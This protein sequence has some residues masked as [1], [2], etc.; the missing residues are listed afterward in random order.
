MLFHVMKM[1]LECEYILIYRAPR[2]NSTTMRK[3]MIGLKREAET[4]I[5]LLILA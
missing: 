1:F 3:A 5:L 4:S 2:L